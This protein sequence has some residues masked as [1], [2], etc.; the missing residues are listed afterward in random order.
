MVG[1]YGVQRAVLI[2]N[3]PLIF[4]WFH[5]RFS[6]A[7][8]ED[9]LHFRDGFHARPRLALFGDRK[10]ILLLEQTADFRFHRI[11]VCKTAVFHLNV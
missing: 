3:F 10:R 6:G 5:A 9:R 7:R 1:Q 11:V 2:F 8:I 4:N